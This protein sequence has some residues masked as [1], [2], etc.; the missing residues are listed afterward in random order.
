MKLG[1]DIGNSTVKGT[2]MDDDNVVIRPLKY[3][4]AVTH[5]HDSKYVTF[6][7]DSD[8]YIQVVDSKLNHFDNIVAVGDRAVDMPGYVEFDVSST[9]FKANNPITTSLLF[10]AIASEYLDGEVH[11]KL[12]VSVPIVEAKSIG[13]IKEYRDLLVGKHTVMV[14]HKDGVGR[15]EVYIDEA[16]V[17]NEGQ[18]GFLGM[19]DT[20]DGNFRNAL[21]VV[22][23]SLG[24]DEDP[25]GSLEDFLIVDIG[26]GTTDLAV[27][28]NKKFN[29]DFSYSVT[30]GYGNLLEDAMDKALLENLTIESRK[31]LQKVLESTNKRRAER[32]E[33]WDEFVRPTK[34]AFVEN[35][36]DT[37]MKTYGTR[38]YFDAIIFLGGGFSAL[39]GY[40][41]DISDVVMRD[42][43]L[44]DELDKRLKLMNKSADLVFGIP[45][46]YSQGINERGLVQVLTR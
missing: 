32:R 41:V 31:D 26:E 29:P 28:R 11:V 36:I 44:F 1:L 33:R 4:S 5:I 3:P 27:F 42:S 40:T 45:A 8:Y 2:M 7:N 22:Y 16:I 12:A 21:N 24:E 23:K 17:M 6:H 15:L 37:I 18:A 34:H 14:F 30:R 20:V 38:D 13:L 43:Y 10:G 9:S 19:L 39:T 35:V 25:I 46:P